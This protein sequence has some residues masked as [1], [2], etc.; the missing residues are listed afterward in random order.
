VAIST[1][2]HSLTAKELGSLAKEL[3]ITS[4]HALRKEEL[5]NALAI[6]S[7]N[8]A[9][10]E[11]IQQ[12]L[13]KLKKRTEPKS[14][15]PSVKKKTEEKKRLEEK[16]KADWKK[17]TEERKKV[18]EEKKK[19]EEKEKKKIEEKKP[20]ASASSTNKT[21]SNKSV[22]PVA[23]GKKEVPRKQVPV[24]VA[25]E[26]RK[27]QA[28]AS[29]Y[30]KKLRRDIST[31][32]EEGR[33]DRLVLLVRDPFWLH[34]FWEITAKTV[35]RAKIA[36]GMFWHTALPIIRIFRMESDGATHPKRIHVRDI[37][38]HG[39]VNN[40]YLNVLNPPSKFQIELG[41][42]SREKKFYPLISSNTVETPQQQVIDGL[43]NLDGNWRGVADDL[44]RIY[45]LSG[46]DSNNPELKKVFEEQLHRPMSAPLLSRYRASQ[47]QGSNSEKTR[48]NFLFNVDVDII[49]H[50]KTDPSVQ[51]TIRN[52]PIKVQPDGSFSIR[53]A[54]PE[55]RHVFS[56]EA[57]GSDGVETQRL[58]L[59]L[60]RNTRILETLFQE[61]TD[62]D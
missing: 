7:R 25:V 12:R 42:I 15:P 29:Q 44:G 13:A 5:V 26:P 39:G 51:V 53:F 57:E 60:E 27:A 35:E 45:K 36:L 52:E 28:I 34:A 37:L 6:K 31:H 3:S 21:S 48:R 49:V 19:V 61:P 4:W 40:W 2:L 47:H 59:T 54:L 24:I 32:S 30:R 33:N 8:K 9:A 46:G 43:D 50:G 16:K 55:K 17:R 58:L 11:I 14:D 1:E 62:D 10:R 41:Y 38:I 22:S 56:M 20:A 23:E 18:V